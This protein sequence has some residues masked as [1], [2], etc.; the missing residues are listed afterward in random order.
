MVD[1]TKPSLAAFAA[2]AKAVSLAGNT[3]W[4]GAYAAELRNIVHRAAARNPRSLQ[5]HLGPSEIGH[6]CDRQV[7]FKLLGYAPTNHVVDP[8]PSILGTAQHAWFADAFKAE[9]GEL[10]RIRW[11]PE[12][13]VDPYGTAG[14]PDDYTGT[15]D[16]YDADNAAVDDHKVLGPTSMALVR[17]PEGPPIYYQ[18]QLKLYGRGFRRLGLPVHRVVLIAWPRTEATLDGL[19]CWEHV[20]TPEDDEELSYLFVMMGHRRQMAAAIERGEI[21]IMDVPAKP[22]PHDCFFCP[23]FR[24][25]AAHDNGPGCPGHVKAEGD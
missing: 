24:P 8:W 7:V 23:L 1:G 2:S 13:R 22:D 10:G 12:Y 15:G 17:S 9:N 16:L 19:Y 21:G 18:R 11:V 4:A 20:L 14:T 5:R 6:E 3:P 25:Q